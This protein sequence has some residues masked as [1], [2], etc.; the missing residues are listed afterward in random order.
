[1]SAPDF[2]TYDTLLKAA[3]ERCGLSNFGVEE[4]RPGLEKFVEACINDGFVPPA[5]LTHIREVVINILVKRLRMEDDLAKH[6]EILEEEITS[7]LFILGAGRVGS[8]KMHRL[9]ANAENIQSIPFWQVLNPARLPEAVR[10]QPDP[11]IAI[12][13]A[14]CDAMRLN[15]PKLYAA[16]QPVATEPDEDSNLLDMHFMQLMFLAHAN[17]PS[18]I[19]WIYQQDWHDAYRYFKKSLQ[20]VQWQNGTLGLPLLLKG[21]SHTPHMGEIYDVFP[22]AKFVQIHRDP[23]TCIAS[24]GTVVQMLYMLQPVPGMVTVADAAR[25]QEFAVRHYFLENLKARDRQPEIPVADYYIEDVCNDAVG[26]AQKIFEFWTIPL[27]DSSIQRM[28][29]WESANTKDR[30]GQFRYTMEGAGVNRE[31]FEAS[32]E[33]YMRRFYPNKRNSV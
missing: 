18:Y 5:G 32:I 3:T 9:L 15:V 10:G 27:S 28:R 21:P 25:M 11:R 12:T 30:F 16:I 33:P 1:M 14:F 2:L 22:N 17:V 29:V 31:Q 6:P 24:L 19:E 13:E 23:A 4:F 20:Y 7:P 8:T 26:V